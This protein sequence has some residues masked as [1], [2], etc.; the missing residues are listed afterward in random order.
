MYPRIC[1]HVRD[2]EGIRNQRKESKESGRERKPLLKMERAIM[3][4]AFGAEE[5]G[6]KEREKERHRGTQVATH[7]FRA[8]KHAVTPHRRE[9]KKRTGVGKRR[10][11]DKMGRG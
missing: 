2:K 7:A 9:K 8:A 11:F 5:D 3:A 6:G 1:V 10:D 4:S